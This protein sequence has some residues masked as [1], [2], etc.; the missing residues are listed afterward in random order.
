M[1]TLALLLLGLTS[2]SAWAACERSDIEFYL[3][4]GFSPDQITR[5]CAAPE[6]R[7]TAPATS[8]SAVAVEA[9]PPVVANDQGVKK[10]LADLEK[11]LQVESMSIE[12]GSLV[13]QQRFKVKYGEE[14]VFGNL[15]EVKPTM[16]VSIKLS[17]M[18]LIK[19]AKRIPI[20]RGAYVLLSGDVQ[21]NLLNPEQYKPKQ[22]AG[23]NEFLTEEVGQNSAKIKVLAEADINKVGADLQELGLLYRSR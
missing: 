8:A 4:K 18:R 21:Q 10:I 5:L 17:T 15:Q 16:Q 23:I 20:L 1:K 3:N 19:A 9:T 7:S 13:F 14:D 12:N 22:L 11:T 2:T 6:A